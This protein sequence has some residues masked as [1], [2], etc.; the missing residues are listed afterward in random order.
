M[1]NQPVGIFRCNMT[2]PTELAE[3]LF[4]MSQE[5]G[6]AKVLVE[7]NNVGIVVLQHLEGANLWKSS[8]DKNWTTTQTNKRIM[9]EELKEGI[10]TGSINTL[11]NI[12]VAELRSIKIDHKYNI[13]LTRANGAHADS[14]VALALAYQCLRIVR[15][16]TKPYLPDWVKAKKAERIINANNGSAIRRY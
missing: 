9:F 3:E 1:T 10:R 8:E 6:N 16:P 12:T 5:Y 7:A 15:L 4:S 2:T 13:S 11:D 14:A